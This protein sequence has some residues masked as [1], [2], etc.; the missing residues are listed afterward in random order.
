MRPTGGLFIA[1]LL[2]PTCLS[3]QEGE[4]EEEDNVSP[5]IWVDYNPSRPF[6]E[7]WEAYGDIGFRTELESNGWVRFVLRPNVRYSLHRNWKLAGGIGSFYTNN[8]DSLVADRWELRPWQGIRLNWPNWKVPLDHFLRLEERFEWDT[9]DWELDASIRLRYRL[10]AAYRWDAFLQQERYWQAFASAEF[11]AKL[12]GEEGQFQEQIR[13][14]LGIERSFSRRARL[15]VEAVW[16]S[17]GE[18]FGSP[19]ND[20]F[21]RVRVFHNW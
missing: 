13:L 17:V 6:S 20:L 15:R 8:S 2:L 10:R 5:Q 19:V 9:R 12:L 4:P 14:A 1:A 21:L 11:F 18:F 7:R 3:A 16:Q